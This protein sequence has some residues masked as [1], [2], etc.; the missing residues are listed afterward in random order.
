MNK[1]VKLLDFNEWV[2]SVGYEK[3]RGCYRKSDMIIVWA[4]QVE[5]EYYNYIH[6]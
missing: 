3:I 1:K 5:K 4:D 2:R 6:L